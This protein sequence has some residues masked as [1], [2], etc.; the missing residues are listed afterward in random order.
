MTWEILLQQKHEKE[1]RNEKLP[2][3]RFYTDLLLLH[4]I[5]IIYSVNA[6]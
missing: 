3:S 2:Q 4:T 6:I 5:I 1:E